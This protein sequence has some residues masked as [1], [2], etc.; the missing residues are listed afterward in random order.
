ML[1]TSF[2]KTNLKEI[3]E[4]SINFFTILKFQNKAKGKNQN[5]FV[6][7]PRDSN[8]IFIRF[9]NYSNKNEV[10]LI[11]IDFIFILFNHKK[12]SQF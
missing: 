5:I 4:L 11:Y 12:L 9:L 10:I 2:I 7:D 3:L 6:N 1:A 8:K